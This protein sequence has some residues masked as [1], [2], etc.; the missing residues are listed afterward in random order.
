[1]LARGLVSKGPGPSIP[2]RC[3][4]ENAE[5]EAG[6]REV[7]WEPGILGRGRGSPEILRE[8]AAPEQM[9][10]LHSGSGCISSSQALGLWVLDR[11]QASTSFSFATLNI[12]TRLPQV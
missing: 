8:G 2:P 6:S 12:Y 10:S 5:L 1:M 3:G 7:V 4:H 9:G 11:G